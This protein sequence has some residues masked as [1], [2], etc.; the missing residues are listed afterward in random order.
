VRRPHLD[1]N[2]QGGQPAQRGV[3]SPRQLLG[4]LV[5]H[6]VGARRRPDD[7]RPAGEHPDLAVTVEQQKRE[8]LVGVAGREQG[9]QAQAA[10][11]DL[12]AVAQSGVGEFA[13]TE[14]RREY[15]SLARS[16]ELVCAGKE[17]GV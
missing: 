2:G 13:V 4:A 12:V 8:V 14:R 16:A 11:V 5:G 1:I 17:I 3:L 15:P 7:Q 9:A 10:E 6:Q